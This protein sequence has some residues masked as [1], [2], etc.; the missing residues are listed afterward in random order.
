MPQRNDQKRSC[1]KKQ[2]ADTEEYEVKWLSLSTCVTF[3]SD[4][5]YF[6]VNDENLDFE[7]WLL[8]V[9]FFAQMGEKYHPRF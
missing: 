6:F 2:F 7:S 9:F 4:L 5:N 1:M 3:K 8:T